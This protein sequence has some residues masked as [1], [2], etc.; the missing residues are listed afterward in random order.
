MDIKFH[1]SICVYIS[2][3]SYEVG[4]Y[5]VQ[6]SYAPII[7]ALRLMLSL[8][9]ITIGRYIYS[10]SVSHKYIKYPLFMWQQNFL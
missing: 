1:F 7:H 10:S 8:T 5:H 3:L 2:V 4:S 9:T 6:V